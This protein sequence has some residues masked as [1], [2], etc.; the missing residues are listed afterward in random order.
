MPTKLKILVAD[1]EPVIADTIAMILSQSGYEAHAVYSGEKVLES[2]PIFQPDMLISDVIMGGLNGIDTAIKI[3]S[4]LPQIKI[5]LFSGQVAT[6]DLLE[7]ARAEGYEFD[8]LAKPV[9]P[10]DLLK[11]L[12]SGGLDPMIQQ[13][14]ND[15]AQQGRQEWMNMTSSVVPARN[16][17][18]EN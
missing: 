8:I 12:Q 18:Q 3:R 7:K 10:K 6:A 1:D 11:K 2:A 15:D 5:L 16:P 9:H 13:A 14:I 17:S 4:A